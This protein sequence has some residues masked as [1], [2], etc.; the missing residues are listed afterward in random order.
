[1]ERGARAQSR[2]T[3]W[4]WKLVPRPSSGLDL[5]WLMETLV[6]WTLPTHNLR[7]PLFSTHGV[8]MGTLRPRVRRTCSGSVCRF[9]A[10]GRLLPSPLHFGSLLALRSPGPRAISLASLL[11]QSTLVKG[12]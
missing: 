11:L 5:A 8:Q 6:I 3:V 4:E 2:L 9:Q 1:M 7:D 10:Q 12:W